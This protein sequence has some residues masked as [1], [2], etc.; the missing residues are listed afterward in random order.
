MAAGSYWRT[1]Y[2]SL[3]GRSSLIF[4]N[5]SNQALYNKCGH[6]TLSIDTFLIS[7]PFLPKP[8]FEWFCVNIVQRKESLCFK[9]LVFQV[10]DAR[11]PSLLSVHNYC[12]HIFAKNFG[13]GNVVFLMNWLAHIHHA[14]ILKKSNKHCNVLHWFKFKLFLWCTGYPQIKGQMYDDKKK[15]FNNIFLSL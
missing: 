6:L 10:L 8:L 4:L 9:H 3:T 14:P 1:S 13:D 2:K 12:F 15:N 11:A 5:W 7:L